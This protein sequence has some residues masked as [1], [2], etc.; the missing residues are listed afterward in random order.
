MY[1]CHIF[2]GTKHAYW[3]GVRLIN[4]LSTLLEQLVLI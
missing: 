4:E 2:R 3:A 1:L